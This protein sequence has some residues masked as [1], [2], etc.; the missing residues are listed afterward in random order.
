MANGM[1]NKGAGMA[2][3][4]PAD[5]GN[6]EDTSGAEMLEMMQSCLDMMRSDPQKM[7]DMMAE[8]GGG[9]GGDINSGSGGLL[10]GG[11]MGG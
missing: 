4:T 3:A 1:M 7:K 6:Q 8:I 10:G 5:E 9:M 11:M 2:S